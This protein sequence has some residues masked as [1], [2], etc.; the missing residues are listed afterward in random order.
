[1]CA[2]PPDIP[3]DEYTKDTTNT[4]RAM[5]ATLTGD[6][7]NVWNCCI[8]DSM[9]VE[10]GEGA[11]VIGCAFVRILQINNEDPDV[12]EAKARHTIK[13]GPGCVCIGSIFRDTCELGSDC[14]VIDSLVTQANIGSESQLYMTS[15]MLR[16]GSAGNR[17]KM[18]HS[19]FHS[20]P[21]K[22]GNDM[23]IVHGKLGLYPT[24]DVAT[25][26][27]TALHSNAMTL[28]RRIWTNLFFKSACYSTIRK[29]DRRAEEITEDNTTYA[30]AIVAR[31]QWLSGNNAGNDLL[32]KNTPRI[33][34]ADNTR[35]WCNDWMMVVQ[36]S[37]AIRGKDAK[38]ETY[39]EPSNHKTDSRTF[40]TS[41]EPRIH[42]G[43][44]FRVFMPFVVR[45]GSASHPKTWRFGSAT[46]SIGNPVGA[47]K[48]TWR[49]FM[50]KPCD[51]EIG[52]NVTIT[53]CDSWDDGGGYT[54][55]CRNIGRLELQDNAVVYERG[56]VANESSSLDTAFNRVRIMDDSGSGL[57]ERCS[58][59]VCKNGRLYLNGLVVQK[60]DHGKVAHSH[61][62]NVT[63]DRDEIAVI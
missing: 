57:T 19:V 31:K 34:N 39:W 11:V 25:S 46:D 59:T 40:Y 51:V 36:F 50:E 56:L 14:T 62:W 43:D 6:L 9:D 1:M 3:D 33:A 41:Y 4:F 27:N 13:I 49:R 35:F 21:C 45:V 15:L 30:R 37:D 63:V 44:N 28:C 26:F 17:L 58:L 42:I 20:D 60:H 53:V 48:A 24:A 8:G 18:L 7:S 12:P 47:Q 29:Y 55:S 32:L 52:N 2:Q 22:I 10:I 38:C 23:L 5:D 16:Y 61:L 54:S